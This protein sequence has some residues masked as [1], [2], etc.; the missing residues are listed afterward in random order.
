MSLNSLDAAV[1]AVLKRIDGPIVLGLPLGIGKPNALVNAL[2]QRVAADPSRHLTILTA[3][4]LE[5]PEGKSDLER[6]FLGPLVERVFKDYPDLDYVKASRAGSLPPNIEVREFFMKTGD[7]LHNERAQQ[8]H[9]ST[10]YTFAAREL[11]LQG[12]NVLAQAVAERTVDGVRQLSFSCNPDLSGE[13][14]ERCAAAGQPLLTVAVI[15]RELPFMLGGAQVAPDFFDLVLDCAQG[16]HTL[17]AP[18]NGKVSTADYAIGLHASS[19]VRDGGT[20]QIGIGSLGDAIAQ[21]LILRERSGGEYARMLAELCPQG[22]HGRELGAFAQGLYGCSEMFVNGFLA[23]MQAGLVR[24]R[25]YADLATQL[26]VNE[27]RARPEELPGG[28][29]MTGGFFIGPGA[30]YAALRDMNEAERAAIDMTRIDYIN[31]LDSPR[32]EEVELK[33]AQRRQ[34]R[35]M[36][37]V[38]KMTILGA[39]ASD[40]LE[41]GGVVSGV[42]GQ[43]NFVA[44]AHALPGARS[45]LMLRA[46]HETLEGPVSNIVARYGHCTI[47]RT[48][49]DIVITEYGVADL[50]GQTDSEVV[51]RLIA[52]ADSRF[53]PGLLREA[54]KMGKLESDWEL[55]EHCRHN[56]PQALDEKLHPF[57]ERGLLPGFPFGTD[58]DEDEIRIIAALRRLKKSTHHPVDL[59]TTALKSVWEGRQAPPAYLK[60]LG[61]D[62]AR[63]FRSLLLRKLFAGNL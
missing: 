40:A 18:P 24:R 41:E 35:F 25:V 9:I 31:Q 44:Q 3:L 15:N 13:V 32:G 51:K 21:A 5:V 52:I 55:P 17:F 47:P 63:G 8:Q 56:S 62:E 2:Y 28:V 12:I 11:V 22:L 29:H 45:I 53:Q 36:N 54:K 33:R 23:L 27:G 57:T 50:R 14:A 1:D 6:A 42:G 16:T 19:L 46:C 10:N 34:A 20:L 4:S 59:V 30:F 58:L 38:M 49:R 61:L 60:R 26:A 39:A 43:Y 48:L 7:Y 37:T